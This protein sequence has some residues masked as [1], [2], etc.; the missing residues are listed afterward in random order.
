VRTWK[1]YARLRANEE[2]GTLDE[3]GEDVLN[4]LHEELAEEIMPLVARQI[5]T[6]GSSRAAR[7]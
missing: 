7:V 6:I 2:A 3:A 4:E 5:A 1:T